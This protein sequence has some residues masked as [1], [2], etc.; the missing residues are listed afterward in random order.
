MKNFNDSAITILERL[1][2]ESPGKEPSETGS[3]M[4]AIT[5]A[6]ATSLVSHEMSGVRQSHAQQLAELDRILWKTDSSPRVSSDDLKLLELARNDAK[7]DVEQKCDHQTIARIL[8]LFAEMFQSGT[9]V[10]ADALSQ[11]FRVL[12]SYPPAAVKAGARH[13]VG[14]HRWPR[15]PLPADFVQAIEE[16]GEFQALQLEL[17]QR[18]LTLR[19]AIRLRRA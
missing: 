9:P 4:P 8:D 14:H 3:S 16:S 1:R 11:W 18:E 5:S 10:S 19:R 17:T 13:L 12:G 6:E 15:L 7:L 2:P